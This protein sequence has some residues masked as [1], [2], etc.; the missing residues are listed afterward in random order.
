M[1][2][3]LDNEPVTI[4]CPK[5]GEK[6]NQMMRWFK[7]DSRSCPDCGAHIDTTELRREVETEEAVIEEMLRD[8]RKTIEIKLKV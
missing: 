1:A 3:S 7:L 5:C 2:F 6:I 4:I 8:I